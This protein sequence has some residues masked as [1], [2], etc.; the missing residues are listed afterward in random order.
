MSDLVEQSELLEKF[1]FIRPGDLRRCLDELK[2]PYHQGKG[3]KIVTT[4]Q[5][6]NQPLI[7]KHD[8]NDNEGVEFV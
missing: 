8:S 3:G 4:I 7:G 2:I 1:G 5:A 6:L